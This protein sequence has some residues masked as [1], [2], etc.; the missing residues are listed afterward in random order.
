MKKFKNKKGQ[1]INK[2]NFKVEQFSIRSFRANPYRRA[3]SQIVG[4]PNIS[5]YQEITRKRF[6]VHHIV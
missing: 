4:G 6:T 3:N 1:V 2:M 5:I